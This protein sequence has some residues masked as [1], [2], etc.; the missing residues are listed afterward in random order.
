M[1][2]KRITGEAAVAQARERERPGA[3]GRT[4]CVMHGYVE[5]RLGVPCAPVASVGGT[6]TLDV[7]VAP[8]C[9]C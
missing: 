7:Q 8:W 3:A 4:P 9:C 5:A 1:S 2:T 6:R